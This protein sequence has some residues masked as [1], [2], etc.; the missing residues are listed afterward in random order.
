[1]LQTIKKE[2]AR[3]LSDSEVMNLVNRKAKV[4][5]Y[6]DLADY[7]NIIDLLQPHGAV[8]LLYQVKPNFGHWVAIIQRKDEIE[9]FDPY[10]TYIDDQLEWT[11]PSNR[12]KFNMDYPHLSRLLFNAPRNFDIIFNQHHFQK[13]KEGVSTCGRWSAARILRKDLNLT[14][15]KNLFDLKRNDND[16]IITKFTMELGLN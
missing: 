13:L 4:V 1:M 12:K 11:S 2:K 7:E 3:A 15:F 10:G 5:L 9:V 14:Q 6:E 8:F 16:D